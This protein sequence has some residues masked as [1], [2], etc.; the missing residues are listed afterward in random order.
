MKC[1]PERWCLYSCTWHICMAVY[2]NT[3]II[4]HRQNQTVYYRVAKVV[5]PKREKLGKAEAEFSELM[6]GLTAKR[7]ELATVLSNLAALNA[8]LTE[9]QVNSNLP[10]ST[11]SSHNTS[12]IISL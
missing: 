8:K 12:N 4:S 3:K 2:F 9:M 7:N 10:L 6:V 11:I 1:W 5:A